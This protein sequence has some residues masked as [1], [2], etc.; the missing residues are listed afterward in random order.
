MTGNIDDVSQQIAEAVYR[1]VQEGITNAM[2]HAPGAPI[3]IVV[4]ATSDEIEL[5]VLNDRPRSDDSGLE[6]SG[7]RNGLIGMRNRVTECGGTFSA[8]EK[9]DG[10]WAIDVHLPRRAPLASRAQI[11]GR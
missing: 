3:R 8:G 4:G 2:K 6:L 11:G 5:L 10:G 7:G 9:P 1:V